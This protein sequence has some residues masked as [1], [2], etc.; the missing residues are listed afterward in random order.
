MF[1][2]KKPEV[3]VSGVKPPWENI[4]E[5][6]KQRNPIVQRFNLVEFVSRSP[7]G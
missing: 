3:P 7:I 6:P 5:I 4:D 1:W 2:K